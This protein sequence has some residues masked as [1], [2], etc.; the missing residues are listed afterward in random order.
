MNLEDANLSSLLPFLLT[1]ATMQEA[2]EAIVAAEA[3]E[4]DPPRECGATPSEQLVIPPMSRQTIERLNNWVNKQ[5]ATSGY[6]QSPSIPS[7]ITQLVDDG[8]TGCIQS[9]RHV[10]NS[11]IHREPLNNDARGSATNP[12]IAEPIP[13]QESEPISYSE[14]DDGLDADAVPYYPQISWNCSQNHKITGISRLRKLP[15]TICTL[16]AQIRSRQN[17]PKPV[18]NEYIAGQCLFEFR[19]ALGHRLIV[20]ANTPPGCASC[21]ML[22]EARKSYGHGIVLDAQSVYVHDKS[23]LRFHCSKMKH[24]ASCEN[25]ECVALRDPTRPR[26]REYA[27]NCRNFVSCDQDFYATPQMLK[28]NGHDAMRCATNHRWYSSGIYISLRALEVQFDARFDNIAALGSI[29]LTGYNAN[30]KIAFIHAEHQMSPTSKQASIEWC[31]ANSVT[32]IKIPRIERASPTTTYIIT[33]LVNAGVLEG[34]AERIVALIRL[35]VHSMDAFNQ[36][37]TTR[38][39]APQKLATPRIAPSSPATQPPRANRTRG[40]TW[41]SN[42]RN[43][44]GVAANTRNIARLA[45]NTRNTAR[46]SAKNPAANTQRYARRPKQ[47]GSRGTAERVITQKASVQK[48]ASIDV[49]TDDSA[50]DTVIGIS[51]ANNADND[52]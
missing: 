20:S 45:A 25:P 26:N 46:V 34:R 10:E 3:S 35:R 37:F 51:A 19:C 21:H 33:K 29:E 1:G 24:S 42:M 50:D 40:G 6:E 18:C 39:T 49:E 16:T 43:T 7:R 28:T 15:C 2:M 27:E 4:Y 22:A 8:G 12:I 31:A 5:A 11:S 47:E 14:S 38:V 30:L 13:E 17:S 32:L 23:I 48:A 41:N 9:T 44:A 36:L 52:Q